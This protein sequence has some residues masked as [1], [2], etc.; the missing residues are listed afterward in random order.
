MVSSSFTNQEHSSSSYF[1]K[2]QL[3]ESHNI[4]LLLKRSSIGVFEK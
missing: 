4:I 2:A 1:A 3:K